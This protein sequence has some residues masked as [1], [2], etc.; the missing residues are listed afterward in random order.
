[1]K[2]LVFSEKENDQIFLIILLT[3]HLVNFLHEGR[4]GEGCVLKFIYLFVATKAKVRFSHW[5]INV[6]L[7]YSKAVNIDLVK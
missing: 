1:M 7:T 4:S 5:F 2:Q 6:S 3:L